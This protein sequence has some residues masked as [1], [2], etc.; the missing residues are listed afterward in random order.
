MEFDTG[1]KKMKRIIYIV[2]ALLLMAGCS[3]TNQETSGN[4][5]NP[6]STETTSPSIDLADFET[7]LEIEQ[8][9]EKAIFDITFSNQSDEVADVTFSSGQRFEL[10]VSDPAG[11]EVYRYSEGKMFTMAL[12]MLKLEAGDQLTFQDAWDYKVKG[13]KIN[14]GIYTVVATVLP[15]EIN[16]G[17]L[18]KDL[19]KAEGTLTIEGSKTTDST[20]SQTETNEFDTDSKNNTAF[21]NIKAVGENGEYTITG[22][23]RVF[24]AVF[25]YTVEDGHNELIKETPVY[26]NEGAPSWSAFELNISIPKE[27]LPENGTLTAYIYERSAKDGSIVNSYY[28]HLQQ[29]K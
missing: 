25:M 13:K 26:A 4:S 2:S 7:V 23:A 12:Q 9:K 27:K 16:G 5:G 21:R 20:S 28:V 1:G 14:P 17:K 15:M 11:N 18:D 24:E 3:T 29:F 19:F 22:E 10:V 8:T 6:D